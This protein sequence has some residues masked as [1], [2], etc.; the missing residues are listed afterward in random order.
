MTEPDRPAPSPHGAEAAGP[1]VTLSGR[2]EPEDAPGLCACVT[3][4]AART[5]SRSLRYDVAAIEDADVGTV[6]VLARMALTARRLG[7]R[8]ALER[9]RPELSELLELCGLGGSPGSGVEVVGQS[10]EREVALGVEEEGDPG[11]P[12]VAQL[13]H[14]D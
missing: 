6:D 13:E 2:I 1:L 5:D 12:A 9:P 7:R 14:L 4:S 3:A 10:E 8:V 11:D